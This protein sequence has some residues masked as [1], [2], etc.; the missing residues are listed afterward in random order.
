MPGPLT[1]AQLTSA[2]VSFPHREPVCSATGQMSTAQQPRNSTHP[3]L[4]N[5]KERNG[6]VFLRSGGDRGIRRAEKKNRRDARGMGQSASLTPPYI[7]PTSHTRES[8]C[9]DNANTSQQGDSVSRIIIL[10]QIL[11]HVQAETILAIPTVPFVTTSAIEH[12]SRTRT[13]RKE[14]G[15]AESFAMSAEAC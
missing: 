4:P 8:Q 2:L 12:R 15:K 5:L 10:P 6:T 9:T 14:R 13:G 7:H 1:E 3:G 11:I